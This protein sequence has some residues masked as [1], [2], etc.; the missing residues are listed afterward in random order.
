[1]NHKMD[2]RKPALTLDGYTPFRLDMGS[3]FQPI[4]GRCKN[5]HYRDVAKS[6]YAT[7]KKTMV[8]DVLRLLAVFAIFHLAIDN[9]IVD[10]LMNKTTDTAQH[11]IPK[12]PSYLAIDYHT[13]RLIDIYSVHRLLD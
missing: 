10:R 13:D 2:A 3:M 9:K 7:H 8:A 6:R 4:H 11:N 12:D 1:M 5:H